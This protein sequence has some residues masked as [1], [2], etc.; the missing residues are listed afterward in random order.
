[1][2]SLQCEQRGLTG[3]WLMPII[4]AFREKRQ[5]GTPNPEVTKDSDDCGQCVSDSGEDLPCGLVVGESKSQGATGTHDLRGPIEEHE[6]ER[7][8]RL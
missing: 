8:N 3:P 5:S 4:G 6:A 1:M 7:L 2:Y